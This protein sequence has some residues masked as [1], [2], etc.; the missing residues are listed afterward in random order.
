VRVVVTGGTGFIG[1][2]VVAALAERGDDVT[3]LTRGPDKARAVVPRG[4]GCI[5]WSAQEDWIERVRSA[6][7]VIHL[8]G[9][10]IA[11]SPW[12]SERLRRIHASRIES[13]DAIATAIAGAPTKPVLVSA[14]AIGIYGTRQDDSVLDEQG[15]HGTDALAVLCEAWEVATDPARRAGARVAIA[16]IGIVLGARG[17]L[18]KRMLPR[19]RAFAGGPLGDGRQW[20]SWIHLDDAV[21]ALLFALDRSDLDGPFNVTGPKPATMATFAEALGRALHRP[22]FLRVP[23]F[24]LRL[25]L[26]AGLA[27]VL[28]T[29]QRAVPARLERS[30]FAFRYETVD[31]ALAAAVAC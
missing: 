22:A 5:A 13:T 20:L 25:G 31:T 9:E 30:G 12:T 1:R 14:S 19:F 3:V 2:A 29:G 11:D 6:Q 21:R 16:R 23:A 26:G 18:L 10:G 24:A 27:E 7:A 8:A 15:A 28:L 4:V 17:G